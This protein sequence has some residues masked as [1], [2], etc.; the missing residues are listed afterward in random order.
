[1]GQPV[2]VRAAYGTAEERI[3][4][5]E[6]NAYGRLSAFTPPG[7]TG[8]RVTFEY[9]RYTLWYPGMPPQLANPA[10][11]EGQVTRVNYPDNTSEDFGYDGAEQPAW[12]YTADGQ[13]LTV[14]RDGLHR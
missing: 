8:G 7:G 11:Y 3:T 13:K 6:Y 14:A 12:R 10:V 5:C 2:K 1:A 9:N 4:T